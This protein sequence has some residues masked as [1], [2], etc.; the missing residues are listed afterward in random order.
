MQFF[1]KIQAT[2]NIFVVILIT[3]IF[4]TGIANSLNTPNL[5]PIKSND[6]C[7]ASLL[8][9]KSTCN[10]VPLKEMP[11]DRLNIISKSTSLQ[12]NETQIKNKYLT[13]VKQKYGGRDITLSRLGIKNPSQAMMITDDTL[14]LA[15]SQYPLIVVDGFADWC[16]YC[17]RFNVS[18]LELANELR[19][20]VAFGLINIKENNNTKIDYNINV[21][22]TILIFKD[23]NLVN[24]MIG[25]Q[26]K[27]VLVE[28]LKQIEP[29]LNMS[30]IRD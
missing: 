24:K 19:G 10:N 1:E 25:N 22:P 15:I 13:T 6:I 18:I 16:S 11:S 14:K 30:K 17:K 7:N 23:G 28:L 20:Q 12:A 21:Y 5:C 26:P 8:D 3:Y 2:A 27:S 9:N 29:N 4:I